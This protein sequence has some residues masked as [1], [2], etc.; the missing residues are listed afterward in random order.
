MLQQMHFRALALG[1]NLTLEKPCLPADLERAV[2]AFVEGKSS[3]T[4]DL[5]SG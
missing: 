5:R 2:R 1:A 3:P 4:T